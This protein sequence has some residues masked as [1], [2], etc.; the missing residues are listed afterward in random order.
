LSRHLPSRTET[1]ALNLHHRHGLPSLDRPTPTLH[2]YKNIISTLATLPTTQ[3]RL[4]FA[5][6]ITRA[7]RHRSSTY[8][9]RPLSLLSHTYRPSTQWHSQW[10]T[11]RP[12]FASRTT[13]G[14][15][16]HIENILKYHNIAQ[17]Y[18]LVFIVFLCHGTLRGNPFTL[19]GFSKY[20][21][22]Y[23]VLAILL[24]QS[25]ITLCKSSLSCT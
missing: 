8:R 4:H 1:E 10:W 13:I 5:S 9:R 15:W 21:I 24:E 18:K 7:S 6:S 16:I 3:P 2:C 22:S 25:K 17:G 23:S 14:M 19:I 12:V 20:F 11:S